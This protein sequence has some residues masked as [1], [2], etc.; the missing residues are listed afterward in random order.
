MF[1]NSDTTIVHRACCL[2]GTTQIPH[3][4]TASSVTLTSKPSPNVRQWWP[5]HML[6]CFCLVRRD[7]VRKPLQPLYDGPC[8]VLW[9]SYKHF[10]IDGSGQQTVGRDGMYAGRN[11]SF[12]SFNSRGG[13]AMG[14]CLY[15][16]V[17]SLNCYL[18]NDCAHFEALCSYK[19]FILF[20]N[21]IGQPNSS[22]YEFGK[23]TN[24][25]QL[26]L[27]PKALLCFLERSLKWLM[28]ILF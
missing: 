3:A 16:F 22:K 7:A 23:V 13:H 2:R 17:L 27:C 15:T 4:T 11:V 5:L 19:L 21:I 14:S 20:W 12:A 26:L 8:R 6:T 28:V 1:H 9:R 25:Q 10:T 18:K 24:L